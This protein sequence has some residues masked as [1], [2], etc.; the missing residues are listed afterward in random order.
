MSSQ[1]TELDNDNNKIVND[2]ELSCDNKNK[3]HNA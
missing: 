1:S 2:I 3:M